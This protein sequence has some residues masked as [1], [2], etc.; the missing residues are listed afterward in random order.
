VDH[1][2]AIR[3]I[4]EIGLRLAFLGVDLDEVVAEASGRD[5]GTRPAGGRAR[6]RDRRES[7]PRDRHH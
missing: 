2:S 5:A 3:L 1:R 7:L 6:R 4:E